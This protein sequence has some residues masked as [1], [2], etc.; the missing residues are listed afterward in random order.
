MR[1]VGVVEIDVGTSAAWELFCVVVTNLFQ[2]VRIWYQ[3]AKQLLRKKCLMVASVAAV[4]RD[5]GHKHEAWISMQKEIGQT[6]EPS[7]LP[8]SEGTIGGDVPREIKVTAEPWARIEA[9]RQ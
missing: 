3:K 2:F 8:R 6:F 9:N 1:E 7:M 5:A 4:E